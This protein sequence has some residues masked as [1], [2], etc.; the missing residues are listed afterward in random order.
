MNTTALNF[1]D[2]RASFKA[3]EAEEF[4]VLVIGAGITG[5]GTARDTAMRGLRVAL[6]DANDI[7]SGTSSRSSKLIHGGLRYLAQGDIGVVREAAN[8]RRILRHLAPHLARTNPMVILARS[9]TALTALRAALWSY[10]KLGH[11]D[12]HEKHK[13]WDSERL[14]AEEPQI[15]AE[16]YTGAIVYPEYLTDDARLTLG[17]ARSAAGYGAVVVTYAIC[18]EIIME[19]GRAAGAIVRSTLPGDEEAARV[20]AR[21]IVNSAGPWLDL[22]RHMEDPQAKKILQLT[23]GI[24]LVIA[25]ERLPINRTITMTAQD[26]RGIFAIPNRDVVYIGT[27]DTFY[28]QAEYWPKISHE[29]VS[30]LLKSVSPSFN[31]APLED[32]DVIALWAGIRPLLGEE[33]KKPSEISRRN[34]I[35]KSPGGI[36]SV[37]GGKLTSYRSMAA[38]LAD[39]CQAA[40]GQKVRPSATAEEPLPGGEFTGTLESLRAELERLGLDSS[41]SERAAYLYGS[42][43]RNIFAKGKGPEVE[44]EFAVLS[45]GALTLEDYWMR[46]SARAHFDL[47][48]G[49]AA[50]EP[51][52]KRMGELLN[53]SPQEKDRQIEVCRARRAAEMAVLSQS[54]KD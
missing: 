17:N 10:E 2:R 16:N 4:D 49:M 8:E 13:V 46:R 24:H 40:L 21:V 53:W 38:R 29:D 30:Y 25:R 41:E 26:R 3:L 33:G 51:A 34:E 39:K 12:K 9:K 5:C 42:E 7:G 23:K 11:V 32:K 44:A 36:L 52:A 1:I 31:T 43:A 22:I 54:K 19:N 28:P 50:L 37:A 35:F 27:T 6:I 15:R 48:G 14:R 47:D 45:E 18:D 20:R